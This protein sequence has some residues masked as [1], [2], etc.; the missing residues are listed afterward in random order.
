MSDVFVLSLHRKYLK[1]CFSKL[2]WTLAGGFK[3]PS[4]SSKD[5]VKR[6]ETRRLGKGL[7]DIGGCYGPHLPCLESKTDFT[8]KSANKLFGFTY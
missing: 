4:P 3:E 8:V 1:H 2:I 6:M 5:N 7:K